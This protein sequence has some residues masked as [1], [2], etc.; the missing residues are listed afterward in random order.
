M[1]ETLPDDDEGHVEQLD[2]NC[3]CDDIEVLNRKADSPENV[4]E[5]RKMPPGS[6]YE[7]WRQYKELGGIG[8]GGYTLFWSVWT[9]DFAFLGFRGKRSHAA[10]SFCLRHKLLIRAFSHNAQA[11]L[12]QRILY[13]QHLK[14][15]Y[16]DRIG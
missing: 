8:A 4:E 2:D 6:I 5:P 16:R 13:D 9:Q 15:Q 10:C 11:R 7:Q 1:A 3:D 14:M 12:K